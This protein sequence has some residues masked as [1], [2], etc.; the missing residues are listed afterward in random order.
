MY[1]ERNRTED[2][3]EAL[4]PPLLQGPRVRIRPRL[5]AVRGTSS[6]ASRVV[7]GGCA[8]R[9][10]LRDF[11]PHR[12]TVLPPGSRVPSCRWGVERSFSAAEDFAAAV[13]CIHLAL[14]TVQKQNSVPEVWVA[15][16]P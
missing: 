16:F 8:G 2:E 7:H 4:K 5:R 11:P 12:E 3:W 15:W 13:A 14:L 6:A 10:S 1:G 9:P